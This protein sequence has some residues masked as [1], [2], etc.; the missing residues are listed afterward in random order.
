M[1]GGCWKL[2]G[3]RQSM[4]GESLCV[5]FLNLSL[6]LISAMGKMYTVVSLGV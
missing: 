5:R 2:I 6:L 4:A 3:C 1:S